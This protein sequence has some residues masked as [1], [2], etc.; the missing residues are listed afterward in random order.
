[1]DL[2]EELVCLLAVST[3]L[4]LAV[5]QL[6][7]I[8]V[9]ARQSLSRMTYLA[10]HS[11]RVVHYPLDFALLL[12][13][14]LNDFV[15]TPDKSAS[16]HTLWRRLVFSLKSLFLYLPLP[17]K[18]LHLL[19]ILTHLL[20]FCH[21][22]LSFLLF[23]L[24]SRFSLSNLRLDRNTVFVPFT[25]QVL[26][27]LLLGFH[28][29]AELSFRLFNRAVCPQHKTCGLLDDFE[30]ALHLLALDFFTLDVCIQFLGLCFLF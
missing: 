2:V 23:Q 10:L 20:N 15:D 7:H 24:C 13:D 21:H 18:C 30:L 16:L 22:A 26:Q 5:E 14:I 1:M 25:L 11:A 4:C 9:S 6:I 3:L 17:N 8:G 19:A 27:L 29:A 12:F 28:H